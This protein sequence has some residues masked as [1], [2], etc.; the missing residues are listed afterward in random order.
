MKWPTHVFSTTKTM[1]VLCHSVYFLDLTV[2]T[3]FSHKGKKSVI[4]PPC[5]HS[6]LNMCNKSASLFTYNCIKV[7][8][9]RPCTHLNSPTEWQAVAVIMWYWIFMVFTQLPC[10][11]LCFFSRNVYVLTDKN[12]IIKCTT[13]LTGVKEI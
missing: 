5:L 1:D 4:F 12:F 6:L 3:L 13:I 2:F 8:F 7:E 10:W 9:V 11:Q